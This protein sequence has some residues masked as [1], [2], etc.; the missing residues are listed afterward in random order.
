MKKIGI[1]IALMVLMVIPAT[2]QV[3]WGVRA[4][5][6]YSSL[7]QKMED[8]FHPGG[9]F[10]YSFAGLVK[11]PLY[12]R[13]SLQPE[14]AFV[15]QGGYYRSENLLNEDNEP[16]GPKTKLNYY[17][18]SVP[19]NLVY[20]F[21][22][23]DVYFS[24]MAGPALDVSLFGRKNDDGVKS[25]IVFGKS[26]S[27]DLKPVDLAINIGGQVEYENFFFSVAALCGTIDRHTLKHEG[28]C[29]IYQNNI[30]F[31]LGYYFR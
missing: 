11:V 10:G 12:K 17:A 24:L 20:T 8:S 3:V 15:N 19:I 21:R 14:V 5:V 30:T 27:A 2:A 16:I 6:S 4:G 25:D 23:T 31:S 28:K 1:V 7:L 29:S 26:R 9:H 18:L 22:F 13:L